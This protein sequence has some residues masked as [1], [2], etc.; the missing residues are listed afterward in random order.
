MKA[1]NQSHL[2]DWCLQKHIQWRFNSPG[3]SHFGGVWE[4]EIRTIKKVL[5]ALLRKQPLSLTDDMLSTL[6]CEVKN[7]LN[8]RPLTAVSSDP[9]DLE[10][11]TPNHLLLMRSGV[12]FPPGLFNKSDLYMKKRWKQVQYLVELF[13]TRWRKEYVSLLQERKRWVREMRS[14]QEGDLVLVVDQLLPRN[15]WCL[16]K[17][18]EVKRDQDGLVRSAKVKVS[19]HKSGKDFKFSTN[20]LE[21]PITKL[22]L[23]RQVQGL[24]DAK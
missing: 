11:L 20:I 3:A 6:M 18:V 21:R 17:V 13:W 12:Q 22:V 9:N 1:W 14:F 5:N 23:I 10:A 8:S 7:I 2:E 24:I 15:L 4:R 19:K 16:G